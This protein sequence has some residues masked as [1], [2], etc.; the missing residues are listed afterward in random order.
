[1]SYDS[2]KTTDPNDNPRLD[3]AWEHHME[4]C[5]F[6]TA[7]ER[8]RHLEDC[9]ECGHPWHGGDVCSHVEGTKAPELEYCKCSENGGL[10]D[11]HIADLQTTC[12]YDEQEA[13]RDEAADRKYQAWRD[14]DV[15]G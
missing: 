7:L 8:D 1:M 12:F 3:A 9:S 11:S 15:E 6:C 2:W 4:T 5:L 10:S 14:R 13:L